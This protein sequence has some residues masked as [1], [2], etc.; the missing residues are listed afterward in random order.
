MTGHSLTSRRTSPRIRQLLIGSVA[1]LMLICVSGCTTPTK[2]P[3]SQGPQIRPSTTTTT[4]AAASDTCG[5]NQLFAFVQGTTTTGSA[6]EATITLDNTGSTS[7][8]LSGFPT[9]SVVDSFGSPITSPVVN[10]GNYSFTS[11]SAQTVVLAKG[12]EA[13]VNVGAD[14]PSASGCPAGSIVGIAPPSSKA[15]QTITIAV[16]MCAGTVTTSPVYSPVGP[17]AATAAPPSAPGSDTPATG[18]PGSNSQSPSAPSPGNTTPT[19]PSNPTPTAPVPT[20]PVPTVPV[21]GQ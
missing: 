21:P 6:L 18:T 13:L 2:P 14:D 17:F 7:C 5:S 1:G 20:V 12:G 11:F 9:L 19:N 4:Q 10:G 3:A 8:A 16:A 15:T